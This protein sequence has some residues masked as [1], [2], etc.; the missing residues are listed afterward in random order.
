MPLEKGSG[1]STVQEGVHEDDVDPTLR[2]IVKTISMSM[3][4]RRPERSDES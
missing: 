2:E 1:L 4:F 3:P